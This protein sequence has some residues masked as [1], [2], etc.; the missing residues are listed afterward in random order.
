MS[1]DRD[2]L[3]A[4]RE[5]LAV[6]GMLDDDLAEDIVEQVRDAIGRLSRPEGAEV[7]VLDGGRE[8]S[9]TPTPRPRLEVLDSSTLHELRGRERVVRPEPTPPS[10]DTGHI[11]L[12]GNPD[13]WQTV[14]HGTTPRGYRV[15]CDA[16]ELMVSADGELVARL[17]TGQSIDVE[18]SIVRT[19]ACSDTPA[20]G[21][22]L[23]F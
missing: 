17:E 2:D 22:Y 9:D 18:A 4:I 15:H 10:I 3:D 23:R 16:G 19:R 21:R 11:R 13:V 14:A 6:L 1:D 5:A 20:R 12:P 8:V 7:V